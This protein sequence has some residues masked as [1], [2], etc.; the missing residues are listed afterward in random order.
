MLEPPD[1]PSE[2]SYMGKP[3]MGLTHS[4]LMEAIV[5][6]FKQIYNMRNDFTI[7]LDLHRKKADR[8]PISEYIKDKIWRENPGDFP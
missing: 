1:D 4:E 5:S 7:V 2:Y 8:T 3:L 6:L